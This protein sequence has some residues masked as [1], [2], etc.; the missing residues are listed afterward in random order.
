MY[1]SNFG[2]FRDTHRQPI[3]QYVNDDGYMTIQTAYG[4]SLVHRVVM[5]TWRP[6]VDMD[7]LTVDHLDH[8]KRDNSIYNLE[9]VTGTVNRIRARNDKLSKD[10]EKQL[11]ILPDEPTSAKKKF[12]AYKDGS[13]NQPVFS[14]LLLA[15][16]VN[17]CRLN[18]SFQN[19]TNEAI[20]K[21]VNNSVEHG[22]Q[23]GGYVWRYE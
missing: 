23:Y 1:V 3:P 4:F 5:K 12:V 8:N 18:K 6:V 10:Q 19:A 9:W 2:H 7:H 21:G 22:T 13:L 15:E 14:C 11:A 20:S 17:W 16:A